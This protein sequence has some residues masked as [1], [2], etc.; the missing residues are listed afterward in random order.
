[1]PAFAGRGRSRAELSQVWLHPGTA[2]PRIRGDAKALFPWTLAKA[3]LSS[4]AALAESIG[5][6]T[7]ACGSTTHDLPSSGI[8]LPLLD[9]SAT[10]AA[11][12]A[13]HA[14]ASTPALVERLQEIGIA[15]GSRRVRS[16]SPSASRP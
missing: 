12:A 10:S 2:P 11:K 13:R 16:F 8:E 4:P 9:A 14:P 15:P 7:A 1:M 5:E 3:F 6:R